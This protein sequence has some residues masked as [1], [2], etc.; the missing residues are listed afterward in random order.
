M[1]SK[2]EQVELLRQL[3]V[4]VCMEMCLDYTNDIKCRKCEFMITIN[5]LMNNIMD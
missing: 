4:I 2:H 1:T 5:K 3:S